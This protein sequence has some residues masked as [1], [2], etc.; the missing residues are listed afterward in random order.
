VVEKSRFAQALTNPVSWTVMGLILLVAFFAF[1]WGPLTSGAGLE[2]IKDSPLMRSSRAI[3]LAMYQYAND[4][5]GN[6]PDGQSSTEVFQKLIDGG[7]ITDPTIFYTPVL[8]L[9]GKVKAS[10][11]KLKPENVCWDITV[12]DTSNDSDFLPVVF[13]TGYRMNYV[14]GGSAVPATQFTKDRGEGIAVT[15]H[16]N[17]TIYIWNDH[18]PDGTVSAVIDARFTATGK[19]YRQ[20]T[21]DGAL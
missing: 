4:H 5:Q 7:Y 19:Q 20:L 21:P 2:S 14:P 9:P 11:N 8:H 18:G 12:P 6:Y 16:S 10:S 17:S 1:A 15:Y 3:A 13:S